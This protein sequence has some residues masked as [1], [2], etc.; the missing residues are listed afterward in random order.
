MK[1]SYQWIR[2]FVKGLDAEAAT[3]ERLITTRTAECDGIE[4]VGEALAD[5]SV[6]TVVSIQDSVVVADTERYGRK[7]IYCGATNCA[8]GLRT[9]YLP[10][11]KKVVHGIESDGM[12]ASGQ[13]LGIN[14]DHL[15]IVELGGPLPAPDQIIEIDNKSL[16]H[17]PDLWGHYGMAREVAAITGHEL[18]DP[19]K[20]DLLP[21]GDPA[22]RIEVEDFDLCP[23][24][25]A[26]VFDNI[27]VQPSPLWLQYRLTAIGLN[28]INNIVDLTNFIMA[29]LAQPMHAYDRG[30]VKGGVLRAR[31]AHEGEQVVA[32]NEETYVC[33]PSNLVIAD[34]GGPVG[35]AGVMGGLESAISDATTSIILEAANFNAS[36]VRKT[37]SAHKI[38]T[39]ASMRFEKAQDPANTT[40]A[41]ARAIELLQEL[42]PGARLV[43][44]LADVKRP[45]PAAPSV[46]LRLD[47]LNRK[48]GRDVP[49]EEVRGILERLQFQVSED[50]TVTVPS[51]R[52]T[53][54]ISV[55]DDLVEEVGRMIGYESIPP[56]A[57]AVS[58]VVPPDFPERSYFRRLRA[59]L[60][61]RGFTEVYNYSFL[62]EEQV[63]EFGLDVAEHVRVLNPIAANQS[64][65]RTSLLPGIYANL[66]ENRKH[67]PAFRIFEIGR[68]IHKRAGQLPDEVP[69]LVT[70]IYGD[71]SGLFELKRVAESLASGITFRA[72]TA[73]S[74]EHPTRTATVE[75]G[76]RLFEL[77]PKMIEGR[78][79]ILDLDLRAIMPLEPHAAKYKPIRRYPSS[80]F[81]LTVLTTIRKPAAN[82]QAD[83]SIPSPIFERIEFV[84]QYIKSEDVK[85]V[86]FRFTLS[87]P[88]RT[89]SNEEVTAFRDAAIAR[90]RDLGYNL[91]V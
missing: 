26:L 75:P 71:D 83:F 39:D 6:A 48:L 2:G 90:M 70:A 23:R 64:L 54:D 80:S 4:T 68:E 50:F 49:A 18:I 36:S 60:T 77:H 8:P 58:S 16:T 57:P 25:S 67:F 24:F 78:A 13:E 51:W 11:G 76:G 61:A 55:A 30:L 53:K 63:A 85:S 22:V 47:W 59:F 46:K 52:A 3:L 17:R 19:V 89:L 62:S 69:H 12:L 10:I 1:F 82:V 87:A 40:R 72:A 20:M 41:L 7:T 81:D 43:G 88:D 5:A 9:A 32:L 14:R 27:K 74:Y 44:G 37:S 65:M 56:A 86:T 42:S 73:R 35:L 38:R 91:T 21:A 29:E 15:G 84:R 79:H 28:P 33:N 34:K 31:R 66:V 45:L